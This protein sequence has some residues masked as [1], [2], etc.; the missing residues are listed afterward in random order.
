MDKKLNLNVGLLQ[1][2]ICFLD[3]LVQTSMIPVRQKL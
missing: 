2:V 1:I 3:A